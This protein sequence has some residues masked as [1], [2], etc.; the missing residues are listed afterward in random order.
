MRA[1]LLAV[2]AILVLTITANARL[3]FQHFAGGT[4]SAPATLYS[5]AGSPVYLVAGTPS[6][7]VAGFP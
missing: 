1:A 6:S 3:L 7:S 2:V 5:V 4:V